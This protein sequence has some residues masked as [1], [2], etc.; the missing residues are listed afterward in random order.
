M[1]KVTENDLRALRQADLIK[2]DETAYVIDDV[3]IAESLVNGE[4]RRIETNGLM[5]ESKREILKG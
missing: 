3:V 4:K 1:Q 2:P 5:L